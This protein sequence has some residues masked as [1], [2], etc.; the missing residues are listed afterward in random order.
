M[1]TGHYTKRWRG[2]ARTVAKTAS[3]EDPSSVVQSTTFQFSLV[4]GRPA[5]IGCEYEAAAHGARRVARGV[6][7][8]SGS[9]ANIHQRDQA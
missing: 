6:C 8:R 7:R 1:P 4:D 3:P 9:G 2:R 5:T